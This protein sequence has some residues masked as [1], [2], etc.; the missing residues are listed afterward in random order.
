MVNVSSVLRYIKKNV[1]KN[2]ISCIFR[3]NCIFE[4]HK[5]FVMVQLVL[6][7]KYHIISLRAFIS[8]RLMNNNAL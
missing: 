2:A 5:D 8:F 1:A 3:K 4:V 6:H 7:I